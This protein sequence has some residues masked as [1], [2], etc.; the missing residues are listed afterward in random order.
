MENEIYNKLVL[1][2]KGNNDELYLLIKKFEPIIKK[3]SRKLNYE[4]A[5]TDLVIFF[6]EFAKSINLEKFKIK[7]D[8]IIVNYI[9]KSLYNKYTK[10]LSKKIL[11]N[12]DSIEYMDN[13]ILSQDDKT[14]IFLYEYIKLNLNRTQSMVIYYKYIHDLSDIEI[15]KKLNISRQAVNKAKNKSLYKLQHEYFIYF[16][17]LE[18][19]K[20]EMKYMNKENE[21]IKI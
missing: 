18:V 10:I 17:Y 6:I 3:L 15:S 19:N 2:K 8:G 11:N 7:N 9:K 5:E 1:I 13:H 14:N 12:R 21:I 20:K 16:I 4:E